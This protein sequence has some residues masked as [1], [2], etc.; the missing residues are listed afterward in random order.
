M[1]RD[2]A[3]LDVRSPAQRRSDRRRIESRAR[4]RR[5]REDDVGRLLQRRLQRLRDRRCIP[6]SFDVSE[7]NARISNR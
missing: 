6:R 5:R 1:H 3:D 2:H 4:A 7:Q